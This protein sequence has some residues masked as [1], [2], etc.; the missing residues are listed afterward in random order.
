MLGGLFNI[1]GTGFLWLSFSYAPA[2][3]ASPITGTNGALTV[4]LSNL[5]LKE[6]ISKRKYIGIILAFIGVIGISILRTE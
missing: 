3:I 6:Q 1:V 5:I 4:I 2:S